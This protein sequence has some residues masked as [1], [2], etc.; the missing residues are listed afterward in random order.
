M[1]ELF[2]EHVMI[3]TSSDNHYY[4]HQDKHMVSD[5][6]QSL[7]YHLL[8]PN[9]KLSWPI[10]LSVFVSSR[11]CSESSVNL[12]PW[13]PRWW[14]L[15]LLIVILNCVISGNWQIRDELWSKSLKTLLWLHYFIDNTRA[16]ADM[17]GL[18][19]GIIILWMTLEAALQFQLI[20]NSV[21][22]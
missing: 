18:Q 20:W 10:Y 19:C 14:S 22:F 3:L 4:E 17:M 2:G 11:C 9:T 8:I 16:S 7:S 21:L 12:S 13:F 15:L 6:S 5:S 1:W